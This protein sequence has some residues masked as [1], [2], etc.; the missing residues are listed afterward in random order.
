MSKTRSIGIIEGWRERNMGKSIQ[1]RAELYE[2]A[3]ELKT[4]WI[5]EEIL[6]GLLEEENNIGLRQKLLSY[7]GDNDRL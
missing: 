5:R 1:E 3:S 7:L 4:D 2:E 6:T